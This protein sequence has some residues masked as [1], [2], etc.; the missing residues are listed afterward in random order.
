MSFDNNYGS[1]VPVGPNSQNQILNTAALKAIEQIVEKLGIIYI[2]GKELENERLEI[3]TLQLEIVEYYKTE[4]IRLLE[5]FRAK[6]EI[7]VGLE[8][9]LEKA[10]EEDNHDMK[11]VLLDIYKEY[12]T[13]LSYD[14]STKQFKRNNGNETM[15]TPIEI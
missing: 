3:E 9:L 15:D 7:R 8:K 5:A 10:V 13:S 4:R 14:T 2:R 1:P 12:I 11:M 6:K